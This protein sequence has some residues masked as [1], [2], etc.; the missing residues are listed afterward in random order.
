MKYLLFFSILFLS[1]IHNVSSQTRYQ[2]RAFDLINGNEYG[3]IFSISNKGYIVL[4]NGICDPGTG[5]AKACTSILSIDSSFELQHRKLFVNRLRFAPT[6]PLKIVNDTIFIFAFNGYVN[7]YQ[8]IVYKSNYEC[9]SL[10]M[11]SFTFDDNVVYPAGLMIKGEYLYLAG[12]SSYWNAHDDVIIVK[13]DKHGTKIKEERFDEITDPKQSNYVYDIIQ[14]TDSNFVIPFNTSSPK[15]DY[16]SLIKFDENLDTIWSRRYNACSITYHLPDITA[17]ADGGMIFGWAINTRDIPEIFLS[18]KFEYYGEEPPVLHKVDNSGNTVWSDTLWTPR[19]EDDPGTEKNITKIIE[20]KNGDIIGIGNYNDLRPNLT[21]A[22][23]FRY[24]PEGK[25][26]WEKI[27]KDIG[28]QNDYTFFLDVKEESNGDIVCTG[29]IDGKNVWGGNADY[30]WMLRVDSLGC[31][32]PGCGILDTL[33]LVYVTSDLI[34]D[35]EEINENQGPDLLFI[36]P[37]PASQNT[38]I[39]ITNDNY[40]HGIIRIYDLNGVVIWSS[41]I[42]SE[43]PMEVDT[44]GFVPGV[45]IVE[46]ISYMNGEQA[47]KKMVVI[48]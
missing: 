38:N 28:Y 47:L 23:L 45:Y 22:W 13:S 6:R 40:E 18:E 15:G 42:Y 27:Y 12:N 34:S 14:L 16:G 30:L 1:F 39:N 41:E 29:Q 36:S 37:N 20:A 24:S 43:S 4:E 31:F 10:E 19:T 5:N 8:W 44:S 26:K 21:N 35:V 2:S 33:Q 9:D 17:T 7:P 11:F 25:L 32:E 46:Y 3:S 48:H